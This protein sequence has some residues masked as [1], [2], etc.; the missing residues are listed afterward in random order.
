MAERKRGN[1]QSS[2]APMRGCFRLVATLRKRLPDL[3]ARHGVRSLSVFG[4][5]VRVDQR[6]GSDLDILVEFE[7]GRTVTLLDFVRLEH[8][9]SDLLGVKVDLVERAGLKPAAQVRI[10]R[11]AEVITCL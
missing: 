4:S 3:R 7:P 1:T 10:L 11:E 2:P 5:F 6:R 8:E 9:L